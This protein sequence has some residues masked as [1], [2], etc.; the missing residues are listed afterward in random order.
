M[1]DARPGQNR[2]ALPTA[3]PYWVG[4]VALAV[5][6]TLLLLVDDRP[7]G[8][9]ATLTHVG[10][11][12]LQQAGLQPENWTYF[13]QVGRDTLLTQFSG[14]DTSLWLNLGVIAGALLASL[15]TGEFALRTGPRKW[16]KLLLSLLGGVLMGYGARLALGCSVGALVGG[17]A[18]FSLHGW[19]FAVALVVGVVTGIRLFRRA[20]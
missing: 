1:P 11:R 8:I 17:V 3:W 18:S 9:T 7:W 20:L 10:S 16:R 4:G 15:A 12:A 2:I 13:N 6:N 14:W 5:V 19:V